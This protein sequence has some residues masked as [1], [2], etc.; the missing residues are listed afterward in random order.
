M[1]TPTSEGSRQK[2][3]GKRIA[4]VGA[5]ALAVGVGGVA[6][7]VLSF[8]VA[9]FPYLAVCGVAM[10]GGG[11]LSRRGLRESNSQ[12]LLLGFQSQE[13]ARVWRT[14]ILNHIKSKESLRLG[15]RESL[16]RRRSSTELHSP[17][18]IVET[19]YFRN[20]VLRKW[21]DDDDDGTFA[22]TRI[23]VDAS[24]PKV[25]RA[26]LGGEN[27]LYVQCGGVVGR[28][29][30]ID[31]V[32]DKSDV[33]VIATRPL[34]PKG[35]DFVA[36]LVAWGRF[37][38]L[39]LAAWGP[40]DAVAS[41]RYWVRAVWQTWALLALLARSLATAMPR[42]SLAKAFVRA[43]HLR[44]R[45][46]QVQREW[47]VDDNECVLELRSDIGNAD[48]LDAVFVVTPAQQQQNGGPCILAAA[49]RISG[50]HAVQRRPQKGIKDAV[51]SLFVDEVLGSIFDLKEALE[52]KRRPRCRSAVFSRPP[53]SSDE[54]SLTERIRACRERIAN[55]EANV[56]SA[57]DPDDR[58]KLV[59]ALSLDLADL[60]R[61]T[62]PDGASFD[63]LPTPLPPPKDVV[64]PDEFIPDWPSD[65]PR[66]DLWRLLP[67]TDLI[68]HKKHRAVHP[69]LDAAV[70]IAA[71]A[72]VYLVIT[73]L[74]G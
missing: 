70:T 69:A 47:R 24:G 28:L 66:R 3:T 50:T 68:N 6:I 21:R 46:F 40:E 11:A 23:Q 17:A 13:I 29:E 71:I 73:Y 65:V 14:A 55:G 72:A 39:F 20:G 27:H 8:G 54:E 12:R 31:A 57:R 43:T 25:L 22:G 48:R 67:A 15:R 36:T 30:Q 64:P 1:C 32:D 58:K 38:L 2:T 4:T 61:L 45:I 18:E 26:L 59:K 37:F 44:P 34:A 56:A 42:L 53:D 49:V 35:G 16:G 19:R 10:T 52:Q 74:A 9:F 7:G 33:A 41:K 63:P 62:G 5:A 60:R 51:A